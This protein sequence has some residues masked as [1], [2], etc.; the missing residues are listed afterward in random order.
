VARP[1][2]IN[3]ENGYY[4]VINRGRGRMQ[5]FR[6]ASDY[7]EFLMLLSECC[8]QYQVDVITYCFMSNHYHLLI[9]T[10]N[11]NLPEFMRQLNGVYTQIF[12]RKYK[13]DGSLFRGRYKS[14]IVQEEFY[15]LQV[16]KYIH[17][18]P[19]KA[20]IVKDSKDYEYC[21]H[22]NYINGNN[23]YPWLKAGEMIKREW[24]IG[25]K[26][27]RGY[28]KFMLQE[29]DKELEKFYAAKKQA[30]ILGKTDYLDRINET[31]LHAKRY[32]DK[33]VPQARKIKQAQLAN[34]IEAKV[35]KKYGV[36]IDSLRLAT[37][38]QE[39]EAR[40]VVIKLIRDKTGM[41]CKE[42]AFRYALGNPRSVSEYCRRIKKK[43]LDNNVFRKAY[44]KLEESCQVEI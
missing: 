23:R 34:T 31:Y 8:E 40:K 27:M 10:P 18:N 2:R 24:G 36:K 25:K 5:I 17:L 16:V 38:G 42:I 19:K 9:R 35:A 20:G 21:S 29:E 30:F 1:I 33:E 39:N 22:Q 13:S 43:C 28:A 14:I 6:E 41:E 37:R 7:K 15:L 11:A 4:H 3:I 12:N 44:Q 32:Y 26:G